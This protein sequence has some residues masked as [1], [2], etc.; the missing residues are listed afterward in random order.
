[1]SWALHTAWWHIYPLGFCGAPIREPDTAPGSHRLR[2]LLAYLDYASDLGAGG[3]LL[4][5]I[6]ASSTHGYDTEDLFRIDPRLGT[7]EDFAELVSECKRRGLRLVLDGVFNHVGRSHP[8]VEQALTEGPDGPVA[9]MFDI[10]WSDPEHPSPAVFEGHPGLV[11]FNHSS[12]ATADHVRAAMQYW[13]ERGA[14]GWRLDAAYA[15]DLAFWQRVLPPVRER[16]SD[17]WFLGEVIHGD[18]P[19]IIELSGLD[20]VTQ[21]RLWKAVWS[22]LKDEN[23]YE[24]DWTLQGHTD[25]LDYFQPQT[26]VGNHDVTRIATQTGP[27]K[28]ILAAVVL[29]TVGGIPSVYYGDERGYIGAKE[30]RFGGDDAIRPEYPE[31]PADLDPAGDGFFDIHRQLFALRKRHPWLAHARTE[32]LEIT[33]ER[34]VYRTFAIDGEL[35]VELDITSSPRAIVR[36]K[37]VEFSYEAGAAV[38]GRS[39]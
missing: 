15:V 11:E 10:D 28:A 17:A 27:E 1:M 6:F 21:Y 12:D 4:G 36:G 5:P 34:Y 19:N 24:L 32:A 14:D 26:F 35:T 31:S 9:S 30:E 20:T 29:F 16:F 37:D 23:F 39:I 22:S 7:E 33:N 3:L 25:F 38:V 2:R 13:L 8:L 18:Y